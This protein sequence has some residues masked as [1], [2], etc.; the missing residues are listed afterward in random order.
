MSQQLA[1]R[2]EPEKLDRIS[3]T[4]AF[5]GAAENGLMIHKVIGDAPAEEA[6]RMAYA[7]VPVKRY[8]C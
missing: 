6:A 3:V 4:S 2:D 8:D 5:G 1:L 7:A